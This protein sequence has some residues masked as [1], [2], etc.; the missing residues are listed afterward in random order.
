[1]YLVEIFGNGDLVCE[2]QTSVL[3][4]HP[5]ART[6]PDFRSIDMLEPCMTVPVR[7]EEEETLDLHAL[8]SIK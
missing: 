5:L 6:K 3:Y 1:M 2:I 4:Q 8:A 7:K